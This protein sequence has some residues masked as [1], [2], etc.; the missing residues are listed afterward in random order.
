M[1]KL[2]TG[3]EIGMGKKDLDTVIENLA[4]FKSQLEFAILIGLK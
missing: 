1:E 2:Q 3:N 4:V